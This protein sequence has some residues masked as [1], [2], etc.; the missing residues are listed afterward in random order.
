M[1]WNIN[2][3]GYIYKRSTTNPRLHT[4]AMH[5]STMPSIQQA[6]SLHPFQGESQSKFYTYPSFPLWQTALLTTGES[7]C[8]ITVH[9]TER[10][11]WSS[12]VWCQPT[13]PNMWWI[14]FCAS[15][16]NPWVYIIVTCH[17]GFT[18]LLYGAS[19]PPT[20]QTCTAVQLGALQPYNSTVQ[21]VEH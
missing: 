16:L 20:L 15:I 13:T 6:F 5:H 21:K 8:N 4:T 3:E 11:I 1:S 14:T 17:L 9:I 2:Q 12:A 10:I 19:P 7:I 18:V